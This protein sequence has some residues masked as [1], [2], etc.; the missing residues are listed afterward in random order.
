MRLEPLYRIRFT[1]SESWA[2]GLD[3]GLP[4]GVIDSH[5]ACWRS[6]CW[7]RRRPD[8]SRSR[9]DPRATMACW[10]L[11]VYNLARVHKQGSVLIGPLKDDGR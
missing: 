5:D 10:P 3:G 11:Q 9:L 1:Y 2:V 6:L 8:R 7:P 4:A